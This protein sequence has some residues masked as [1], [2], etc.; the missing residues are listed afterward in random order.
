MKV[1]SPVGG[2]KKGYR[3]ER[4]SL[5]ALKKLNW[6]DASQPARETQKREKW[7]AWEMAFI[8]SAHGV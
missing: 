8:S 5:W 6:T 2:E 1:G 3:G 4:T 7:A